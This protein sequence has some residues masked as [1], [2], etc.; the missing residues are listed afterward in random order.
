MILSDT[1]FVAEYEGISASFA[2]FFYRST[3]IGGST[4]DRAGDG[5]KI[6]PSLKDEQ[7]S[8]NLT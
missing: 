3:S 8:S 5:L 7:I 6:S 2:G 1:G 4:H